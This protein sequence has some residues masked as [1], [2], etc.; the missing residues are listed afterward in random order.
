MAWPALGNLPSHVVAR[1][2]S[3]QQRLGASFFFS[4]G[5]G[6]VG[7]AGKFVT[8]I[9]LQLA[10]SI[11][12]SSQD[13]CEAITERWDIASKSLHD[14]WQQLVLH[15]LSKLD[16]N[17][18]QSLY[19]L[20]VDAL[21]ECDNENDIRIVLDLLAKA[22][23]LERVRLRVFLT[24]KPEISIRHGFG[25]MLDSQHQEFI[26]HN[27]SPSIVDD[28]ISLFFKHNLALIVQERSLN[29]NWPGQTTINHLVQNASGL[30]IWAATACRFI[31]E[32]F[33]VETRLSILLEGGSSTASPEEHLNGIYI[34]VLRNTIRPEYLEQ[35]TQRL[36]GML[37]DVLGTIVV[38]FSPLSTNSLCGLLGIAKQDLGQVLMDSHAILDI[39]KDQRRPIHLHHPS[40]RDFLLNKDRCKD[41]NFW[42]NEKQAHQ[43]LAD[44]CIRLMSTSLKQ[45]ICGLDAPGRLVSDVESGRVEQCLSPE[46]QYACLYWVQH[47]QKSG[48]QL[49][50]NDQVHLFLQEH[51]LHWLEALGWMRKLSEG[52]YAIISLEALVSVCIPPNTIGMSANSHIVC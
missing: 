18:S 44:S 25:H 30:F 42:V 50:D 17:G 21:D 39:P 51:L 43:T 8:S 23:S 3:E 5:G 36:Y 24:S 40:F 15:P 4:R 22:R 1:T 27:I 45:D 35:E 47:L 48:A 13:I 16:G 20:V 28:D 49:R 31:R 10:I 38:L 41:P 14:Q 19:V 52:I 9:A 12:A 11:P 32:G 46:V 29:S 33:F 6:D 34:A 2:Y 26:L 37:R 7:H